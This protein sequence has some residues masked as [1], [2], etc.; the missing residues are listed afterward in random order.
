MGGFA[1]ALEGEPRRDKTL[2]QMG[3]AITHYM[4]WVEPGERVVIDTEI[5]PG[6]L[7]AKELRH[8]TSLVLFFAES[9]ADH[10]L[11]RVNLADGAFHLDG[12][13]LTP[14]KLV[15]TQATLEYD[16]TA[17]LESGRVRIEY[18]NA[19]LDRSPRW[20]LHLPEGFESR[21]ASFEPFL[22]GKRLLTTQT[23]RDLFRTETFSAQEGIAVRDMTFLFTDLKGSTE[24]YERVGDLDAFFL[25]RQHFETLT[26]SIAVHRGSIVKTIG[27][28]VMA[29]FATPAD[30]VHAALGMLAGM[31][32][33]NEAVS[34]PLY[35]KIAT[36]T[37]WLLCLIRFARVA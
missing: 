5:P 21:P 18:T 32:R 36:I 19:M 13:S 11:L 7:A 30:A 8:R 9:R 12:R 1:G 29:T 22:S 4:R 10:E 26:R 31:A 17:D 27:D 33:F 2:E 28:A 6:R 16:A 34:N 14:R 35:L 15:Q 24:L 37:A 3:K 20:L 23:F 25:V